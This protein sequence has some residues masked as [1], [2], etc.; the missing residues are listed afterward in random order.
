MSGPSAGALGVEPTPAR[1]GPGPIP[2]ALLRA[3][4]LSIGRRVDGMLA[5]DHR[6]SLLGR[7]TELAQVRPYVAGDDVRLLG[8]T[9]VLCQLTACL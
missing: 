2:E 4:E 3:L 7:G 5:G 8:F 1:P 6:S 9:S